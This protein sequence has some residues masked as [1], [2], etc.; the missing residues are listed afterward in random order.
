M[1]TASALAALSSAEP[2]A[3][4]PLAEI[5]PIATVTP[6]NSSEI[7]R[8]ISSA[9]IAIFAS[10]TCAGVTSVVPGVGL[11][12]LAVDSEAYCSAL[13]INLPP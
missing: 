8:A 9:S 11:D 7:P 12:L 3:A 2:S 1:R 6:T 4:A 5:A 10:S 13:I